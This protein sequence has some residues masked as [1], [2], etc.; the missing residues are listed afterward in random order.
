MKQRCNNLPGIVEIRWLDVSEL[1][2][3]IEAKYLA[4]VPV[5]VMQESHEIAFYGSAECQA[6]EE[7]D[8]NGRWEKTTLVFLTNDEL[9]RKAAVAWVVKQAN[10]QWWLIGT[11][12]RAWPTVKVTNTTGVPDGDRAVKTVEI[13]HQGIKSLIPVSL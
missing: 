13:T 11:A 6:V 1:S 5:A 12:E 3:N 7:H 9:P 8:N 2:P 10:G 4:G